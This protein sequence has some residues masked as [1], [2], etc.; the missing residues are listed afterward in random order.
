MSERKITEAEIRK[1]VKTEMAYLRAKSLRAN[2]IR[3]A[4]FLREA[5]LAECERVEGYYMRLSALFDALA[6]A[7]R[8]RNWEECDRVIALS[9]GRKK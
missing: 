3:F 5:E 9:D 8:R 4:R 6:S 2:R 7:A 1:I